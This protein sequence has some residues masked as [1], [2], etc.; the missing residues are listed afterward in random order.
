VPRD[1]QYLQHERRLLKP[2]IRDEEEI[3][4]FQRPN[5]KEDLMT[6]K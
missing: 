5:P 1:S 3:V 4:I 2:I 6:F